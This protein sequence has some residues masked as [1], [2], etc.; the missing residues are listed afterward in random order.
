MINTKTKIYAL[1]EENIKYF[2]Y[3]NKKRKELIKSCT[4]SVKFKGAPYSGNKFQLSI[5]LESIKLYREK[6]GDNSLIPLEKHITSEL[7]N[8]FK[9]TGFTYL[10]SN[11]LPKDLDTLSILTR[12]LNKAYP[13]IIPCYDSIVKRNKN[14]N[15]FIPTWL[16][17]KNPT[18]YRAGSNPVHIDAMLNFWLTEGSLGRRISLNSLNKLVMNHGLNNYW[19]IPLLYTPY[20]FTKLISCQK[21]GTNRYF[22]KKIINFLNIWENK[23]ATSIKCKLTSCS[24]KEIKQQVKIYGFSEINTFLNYNIK[25]KLG[26]NMNKADLNFPKLSSIQ[27]T[28]LYWT[29]GLKPYFN[30][31]IAR[32]LILTC[33]LETM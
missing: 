8:S 22:R 11:I 12:V 2:K 17:I 10:N 25:K 26:L 9:K 1:I 13:K 24:F 4:E 32:A 3:Y 6:T 18:E 14:K 21:L 20:L 31:P 33:L 28:P 27:H 15:K 16:D 29:I 7:I 19:Y 23:P 5:V 30:E